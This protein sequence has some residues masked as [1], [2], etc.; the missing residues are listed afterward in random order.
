[1]VVIVAGGGRIIEKRKMGKM[2]ISQRCSPLTM[3]MSSVIT[4]AVAAVAEIAA[5]VRGDRR[6]GKK[7][8]K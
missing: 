2:V 1:M 3:A 7:R 8:K 6:R 4:V 5:A